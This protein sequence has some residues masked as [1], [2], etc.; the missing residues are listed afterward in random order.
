MRVSIDILFDHNPLEYPNKLKTRN[1][2]K[3]ENAFS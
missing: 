1:A 2:F 3:K